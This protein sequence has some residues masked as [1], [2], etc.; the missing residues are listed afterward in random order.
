MNKVRPGDPVAISAATWNEML[1]A[2]ALAK[3]TKRRGIGIPDGLEAGIVRVKNATDE[4]L[5]RFAALS[6]G[7][8]IG[9]TPEKNELAFQNEPAVLFGRIYDG[10]GPWVVLQ[11]PIPSGKIGR[12]M[13][14]GVT[15]AQVDV[16][17]E[18]HEFA[19]P[20]VD[21]VAGAIRSAASGTARILWK[22]NE[23]GLQWCLLHVGAGSGAAAE[24][25]VCPAVIQNRSAGVYTVDLYANGILSSRTGRGQLVLPEVSML[26]ELDTGT[27]VLA[28]LVDVATA[29]HDVE[30]EPSEEG[31]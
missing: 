4:D 17:D 12:G 20:V 27:I 11:E 25:S 26:S 22:K 5:D 3:E 29:D 1:D 9:V 10:D 21:N 19:E 16:A 13:L 14:F 28:H 8:G 18:D 24:P 15:P 6:I 7:R 2:A 23:T 30:G 31:D